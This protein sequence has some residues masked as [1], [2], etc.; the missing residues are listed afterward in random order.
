MIVS[1]DMKAEL[2]SYI[3][4]PQLNVRILKAGMKGGYRQNEAA[5]V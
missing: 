3:S 2:W 1:K 4:L 5:R